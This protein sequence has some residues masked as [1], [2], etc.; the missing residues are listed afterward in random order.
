MGTSAN[1]LAP[2]EKHRLSDQIVDRIAELISSGVYAVGTRLPSERELARSFEVS[3]PLVREALRII[4][5]L[6]LI[7]VRPG[8]GAI[9]TRNGPETAGV[10]GY[11]C[12]H[13]I[14]VLAM[15]EVREV[16][17]VRMV[18]LAAGRI[19]DAELRALRD[20]YRNQV[21]VAADE[22]IEQIARLDHEF[23]DHVYRA[24]RSPILY[25]SDRYMRATLNN[26]PTNFLTLGYRRAQSLA[27]HE[28]IVAALE[29][30]DP[31]VAAERAKIHMRRSTAQIRKVMRDRIGQQE[32]L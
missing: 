14:E 9:V 4:E 11:Y 26:Q 25:E 29:A 18:A 15:L 2:L 21:A 27:E 22:G 5:S 19:T 28:Q 8:I 13:P 3:R 23:H 12:K 30:R 7:A 10:A 24:A 32:T 20:L 31:K 16:L 6:G 17:I 1:G